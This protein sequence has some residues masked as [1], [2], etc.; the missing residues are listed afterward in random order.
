MPRD[1]GRGSDPLHNNKNMPLA[2]L[3]QNLELQREASNTCKTGKNINRK[4]RPTKSA[5]RARLEGRNRRRTGF[6]LHDV[7][8]IC[9]K[10][11]VQAERNPGACQD[12]TE[13]I[14]PG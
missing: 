7:T 3:S 12:L 5:H 4:E 10:T 13:E 6:V 8:A 2:K 1:R 9:S 14:K 11:S